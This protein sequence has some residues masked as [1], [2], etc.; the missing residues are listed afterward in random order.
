MTKKCYQSWPEL[1]D[2]CTLSAMPVGRFVLDVHGESVSLWPASDK[3][4]TALQIINHLQDCVDDYRNLDR[5]YL[6]LDLLAAHGASVDYLNVPPTENR[7]PPPLRAAI[8]S[9]AEITRTRL[10]VPASEFSAGIADLSLALEVHIIHQLAA[11]LLMRLA[12]GDPLRDKV[13][14]GR[15]AFGLIALRAV[16]LGFGRRTVSRALGAS[17]SFTE[18]W[19]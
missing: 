19:K 10:L 5:V 6:P 7:L 2:Y 3:L 12:G 8:A 18:A 4:C 15:T 11:A 9:L 17:S 14:L 13:R 16:L 1:I